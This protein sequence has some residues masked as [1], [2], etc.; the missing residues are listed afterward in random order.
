[1]KTF[2]FPILALCFFL[3][4]QASCQV[5]RDSN[6]PMDAGF[7]KIDRGD[8][9]GAIEYLTDLSSRDFRPEVK[10]ALSSAY[11]GRAGLKIEGFWDF[12]QK[13]KNEPVTTE[14]LIQQPFYLH[15]KANVANVEPFLSEQNRQDLETVFQMMSALDIYRARVLTIPYIPKSQRGDLQTAIEILNQI[16]TSGGRVYRAVLTGAFLRSELDDG[17]DVWGSIQARINDAYRN[18]I[19]AISIFCTPL[20]GNFATWL[21]KEFY[22]VQTASEDLGFAFPSDTQSFSAFSTP[23]SALQEKIPQLQSTLVPGP[24]NE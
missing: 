1:M 12:A 5:H 3:I 15:N 14:T 11:A 20:T 18:P 21:G 13:M 9:N 22:Y 24:C 7:L 8:Y 4:T 19:E 23:V 10:V 6:E 16:P 17:F 2:I